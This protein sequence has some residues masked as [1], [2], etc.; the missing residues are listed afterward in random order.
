MPDAST[1]TAFPA[2][3]DQLPT[4]AAADSEQAPGIEHDVMHDKANGAINALQALLGVTGSTDPG[5]VLGM[6]AAL[7]ANKLNAS[8]VGADNGVAPLVDG[9]VPEA[10]LPAFAGGGGMFPMV[11]GAVPPVFVHGPDGSL[12]YGPVH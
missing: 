3:L 4:I 1:N 10:F 12:V 5:T 7:V 6:I 9:R 8:Q 2:A 11:T